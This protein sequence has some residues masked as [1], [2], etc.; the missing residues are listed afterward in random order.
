MKIRRE[1]ENQERWQVLVI[2]ADILSINVPS[3]TQLKLGYI[4]QWNRV[5]GNFISAEH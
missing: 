1:S 2:T 5:I 4:K 3:S